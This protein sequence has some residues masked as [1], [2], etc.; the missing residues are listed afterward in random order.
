MKGK[1]EKITSLDQWTR[2][3]ES[4]P[5]YIATSIMIKLTEEL[6]NQLVKKKWSR[7]VL[8][9][10]LGCSVAYITK[11]LRGEENLT[12]K[13][14]AQIASVFEIQ[15]EI[16]LDSENHSAQKTQEFY[17]QRIVTGNIIR[18]PFTNLIG[19]ARTDELGYLNYP[20]PFSNPVQGSID[21]VTTNKATTHGTEQ[22]C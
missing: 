7:S 14:I 15:P 12:I 1:P 16:I 19:N 4:D 2:L 3:R 10:K 18:Y 8:A 6:S 13:K 9:R 21:F 5:E 20:I 11:L 17:T 22:P